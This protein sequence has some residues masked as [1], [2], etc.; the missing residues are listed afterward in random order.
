LKSLS[1][2]KLLRTVASVVM[3]LR[4]THFPLNGYL[5][6]IGRVDSA[7]CLACREDEED[8]THFL[9]RC[10]NYAHERWPLTQ[11]ATKKCKPLT[12]Q[13][14]LGDPQL[15]LPLAAYIHTT[16][17]FTRPGECSTNQTRNTA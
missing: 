2:P 6:G 8:I 5:K 3:Q 7:R 4:L 15:I 1:N 9:L 10:Q 11:H 14:I 16:G 17:R 13:T 12:L